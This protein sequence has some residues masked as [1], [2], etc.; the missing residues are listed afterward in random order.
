MTDIVERLRDAANQKFTQDEQIFQLTVCS[1]A[2][3][4]IERL[5]EDLD[6]TQKIA[7]IE[8][9]AKIRYA[10]A[11]RQ[12]VELKPDPEFGAVPIETA[13]KIANAALQQKEKE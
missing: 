4:V 7:R 6:L 9:D 2:A 11:L 12:I 1:E 10:W 5:R 8:I 3:E 13:Q